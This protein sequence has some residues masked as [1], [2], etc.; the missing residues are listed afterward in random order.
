MSAYVEGQKG[1]KYIISE[2]LSFMWREREEESVKLMGQALQ[3]KSTSLVLQ[4]WSDE[5][6][7]PL[8]QTVLTEL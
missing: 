5:V 3:W 2:C 4:S 7:K 6:Y 1:Q 8:G